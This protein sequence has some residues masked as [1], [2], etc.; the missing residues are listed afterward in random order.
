MD[1]VLS[2]LAPLDALNGALHTDLHYTCLKQDGCNVGTK[3]TLHV[4]LDDNGYYGRG[5]AMR[6]TKTLSLICV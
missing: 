4:I 5:G 3:D 1:R 2:I 6:D